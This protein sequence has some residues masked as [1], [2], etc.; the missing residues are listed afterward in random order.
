[1]GF[2]F[3]KYLQESK[4]SCIFASIDKNTRSLHRLLETAKDDAE[5][6]TQTFSKYAAHDGRQRE[7]YREPYFTKINNEKENKVTMTEAVAEIMRPAKKLV[8]FFAWRK[9]LATNPKLTTSHSRSSSPS[10]RC[11]AILPD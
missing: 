1:M 2:S 3:E 8:F 4:Q 5:T 6:A 7:V 11:R 10:L 9:K